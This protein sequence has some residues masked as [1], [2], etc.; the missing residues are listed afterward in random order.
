MSPL[1]GLRDNGFMAGHAALKAESDKVA[2]HKKV[3]LENQHVFTPL[4]SIHLGSWPRRL[5]RL[6]REE[7]RVEAVDY[8][9]VACFDGSDMRGER[10]MMME[11]FKMMI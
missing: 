6:A 10:K 8:M 5:R 11:F 2:K 7:R 1:V 9:M 3:C 4:L